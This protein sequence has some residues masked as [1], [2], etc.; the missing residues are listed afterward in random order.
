MAD[1][2]NGAWGVSWGD[3]WGIGDESFLVPA[4][5]IKSPGKTGDPR[6][7]DEWLHPKL[8]GFAV[9]SNGSNHGD[10]IR[11]SGQS[12][13]KY[14]SYFTKSVLV[15][16]I[17][18]DYGV[19][20]GLDKEMLKYPRAWGKYYLANSDKIK[21][22]ELND[23][24]EALNAKLASGEIT[25]DEKVI[26]TSKMFDERLTL[27]FGRSRNDRVYGSPLFENFTWDDKEMVDSL[28]WIEKMH[29]LHYAIVPQIYHSQTW[30]YGIHDRVNKVVCEALKN[31]KEKR[32]NDE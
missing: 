11:V 17:E 29:E 28:Y 5:F 7:T 14:E 23:E 27:I 16:K 10:T 32:D 21:R 4:G 12:T 25:A 8:P 6:Y 3:S 1:A 2:W 13:T 24:I 26:M 22:K 18:A 15:A 30:D 9:W 20:I 31:L 19:E